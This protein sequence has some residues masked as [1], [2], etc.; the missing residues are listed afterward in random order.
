ML[1]RE[2]FFADPKAF[3]VLDIRSSVFFVA[4]KGKFSLFFLFPTV[5]LGDSLLGGIIC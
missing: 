2:V 3:S 4:F 1:S 5:A